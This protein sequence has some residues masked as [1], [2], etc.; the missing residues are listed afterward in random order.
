MIIAVHDKD[1]LPPG[2]RQAVQK[3]MQAGLRQYVA[4]VTVQIRILCLKLVRKV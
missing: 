1:A 2:F 4:T 3:G